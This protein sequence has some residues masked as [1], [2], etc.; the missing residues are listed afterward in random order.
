MVRVRTIDTGTGLL[1]TGQ[2]SQPYWEIFFVVLTP[3]TIAVRHAI[4]RLFSSGIARGQYYWVLDTGC[5][6]WYRS[7]PS[8]GVILI[9]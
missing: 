3:N 5:L 7:N 6:S 9:R 8:H 4:E 2:Y 1:G